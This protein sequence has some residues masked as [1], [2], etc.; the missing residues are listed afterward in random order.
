MTTNSEIKEIKI[1]LDDFT[2]NKLKTNEEYNKYATSG[3]EVEEE[4]H[5]IK[6]DLINY[7]KNF[8]ENKG[9]DLSKN[10]EFENKEFERNDKSD[11]FKLW[12]FNND[13]TKLQAFVSP[14][15]YNGFVEIK[16]A[17][18]DKHGILE[19]DAKE[20]LGNTEFI[21]H[22]FSENKNFEFY[23]LIQDYAKTTI[24]NTVGKA[25]K[26]IEIVGKK[27]IPDLYKK[28]ETLLEEETIK[29]F[30][31]IYKDILKAREEKEKV[32]D[33]D[34][35]ETDIK[36]PF[37]DVECGLDRYNKFFLFDFDTY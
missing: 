23:I 19:P 2:T 8:F 1:T 9:K 4:D 30:K 11:K 5:T 31:Y 18:I 27:A 35:K 24:V 34:L 20:R 6:N 29:F 21:Y 32:I 15:E 14:S 13:K 28:E 36:K 7:L 3:E 33:P 25:A 26:V 10:A 12:R 16:K 37:K 17:L 22:F